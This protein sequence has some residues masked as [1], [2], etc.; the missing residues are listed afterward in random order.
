MKYFKFKRFKKDING[1]IC[2][3]DFKK[4]AQNREDSKVTIEIYHA[5]DPFTLNNVVVLSGDITETNQIIADQE[6]EIELTEIRKAEFE[7]LKTES[8]TYKLDQKILENHKELYC[9]EIDNNKKNIETADIEYN[10]NVY[11]AGLEDQQRMTQTA[12]LYSEGLP[13]GF[14]WISKD[15]KI[16]P[17]TDINDFKGIGRAIGA[18]TMATYLKARLLKD[19]VVAAT[20]L[21]ELLALTPQFSLKD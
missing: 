3:L 10:G 18:R 2:T 13:S 1:G 7:K 9:K 8:V 12:T 5:D 4:D 15:N 14:G 16:I 20:S 17:F 11:A 19:K 21:E 6:P